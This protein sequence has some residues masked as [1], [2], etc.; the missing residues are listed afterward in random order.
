MD[1]NRP[2]PKKPKKVSQPPA[3]DVDLNAPTPKLDRP[4]P[5]IPKRASRPLVTMPPP[6]STIINAPIPRHKKPSTSAKSMPVDTSMSIPRESKPLELPRKSHIS[7]LS[8]RPFILR[9]NTKGFPTRMRASDRAHKRKT[10]TEKETDSDFLDSD[11]EGGGKTARAAKRLKKGI[12]KIEEG[13]SN[14]V[15]EPVQIKV[16]EATPDVAVDEVDE[17]ILGNQVES[18]PAGVLPSLWYSRECYIH[19]WVIEK[20]I[21][22][23]TRPKVDMVYKEEN[24]EQLDKATAIKV[25]TKLVNAHISDGKKRMDISRLSARKCPFVL[26]AVAEREERMAKK[27]DRE[28][29]FSLKP[30][31]DSAKEEVLLIK[32]RGRS[33]LHCSWERASDLERLDPTNNTAKGKIKRYYQ[34]QYTLL[35]MNW[36]TALEEGRIAA[37]TG[38]GHGLQAVQDEGN[39]V[40]ED[41]D[42][43]EENDFFSP[44][45]IEVERILACD[46]KELDANL[47]ARQRAFNIRNE[48]EAEERRQKE[49]LGMVYHSEHSLLDENIMDE[50]WDPEDYVRYVVKWKGLQVSEITWEYWIHIKQDSVDQA[51]DFWRRQQAPH[52]DTIKLCEKAHPHMREY[53]KLVVS[54]V[55]GIASAN[56]PIAKLNDGKDC[57]VVQNGDEEENPGAGLRL[58]NYQLEGVNWLLWNWWNKRSCILADEMGLG[59]TIQVCLTSLLPIELFYSFV[60]SHSIVIFY[61]VHVFP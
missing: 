43:V 18:P 39:I 15:G 59:K 33:Y 51:E 1:L 9:I 61:S 16:E 27:E 21:G 47:L 48:K 54:P 45:C 2:I 4:I 49:L 20:I 25:Q 53:K 19:V 26:K 3:V 35:G 32:W 60:L 7:L 44:D 42:V 34:G 36:K 24:A 10:Y 52:P 6:K 29:N 8:E 41:E 55:F 30:N 46:E 57:L 58:R 38:H 23:K 13:S 31:T 37:A 28:P 14:V 12:I 5:K 50:S 22:W 56:R 11:S 17:V 40:Q